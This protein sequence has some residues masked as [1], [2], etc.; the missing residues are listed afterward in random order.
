MIQSM[1]GILEDSY[2]WVSDKATSLFDEGQA[3][4]DEFTRKM[5]ELFST[6]SEVDKAIAS[7][8][9][10]SLRNRLIKQKNE[11]RS[12]FQEYIKPAWDKLQAYLHEQ[13]ASDEQF[14]VVGMITVGAVL[15]TIT[16]AMYWVEKS[17]ETE[18]AILNDPE[19]KKLYVTNKSALFNLPNGIQYALWGGV[20]LFLYMGFKKLNKN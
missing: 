11:S 16:V 1:D 19:L 13:D 6:Q 20:A 17:H 15:T 5:E 14:G 12:W 4:I 9:D 3:K 7:L 10:G 8:P 2:N 18:M